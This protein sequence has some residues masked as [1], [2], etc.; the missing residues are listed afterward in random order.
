MSKA[1]GVLST[2]LG[3]IVG[4]HSFPPLHKAKETALAG[5]VPKIY[6]PEK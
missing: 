4:P 1:R 2:S 5:Q 6:T 3:E